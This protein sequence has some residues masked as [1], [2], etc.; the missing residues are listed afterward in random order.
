[1]KQITSPAPPV[2]ARAMTRYQD[3]KR[4]DSGETMIYRDWLC[5]VS[6]AGKC[7]EWSL[8]E[9]GMMFVATASADVADAAIADGAQVLGFSGQS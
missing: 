5:T 4:S 3:W 7:S 6:P 2:N 9:R 8:C 1:M